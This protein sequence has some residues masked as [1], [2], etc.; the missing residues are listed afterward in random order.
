MDENGRSEIS[1]IDRELIRAYQRSLFN[2]SPASR[3][4]MLTSLRGLFRFLVR[5]ELAEAQLALWI[6]LPRRRDSLPKPLEPD[7]LQRLLAG[8][9]R[10]SMSAL[11]DR[12]LVLFLYSTGCRISEALALN[13]EQLLG[14]ADR[15][16]IRG[17][18]GRERYVMLTQTARR[19]IGEYLEGR[20]DTDA[21]L[22]VNFDRCQKD[23][24]DGSGPIRGLAAQDRPARPG[25]RRL[26]PAGARHIL[27]QVSLRLGIPPFS[28]HQLRHTAGTELLPL[29]DAR[30]VQEMLGHRD[31]KT[32]AV[33]AK[34]RDRRKDQV[35]REFDQ[36]MRAGASGGDGHQD[37]SDS[38]Q[39]E[40]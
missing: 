14:G 5:E 4:R 21:A 2:L 27:R 16:L 11:R 8:L 32:V 40:Q 6:D 20:T 7:D 19:A 24:S 26:T 9:E 36:L 39:L 29:S 38:K 10:G 12:A 13:R 28:P 30:F 1:Q 35:Y 34:I 37:L 25:G 33:Y 17:K 23:K 31:I 3:A 18:G 22:F 15:V